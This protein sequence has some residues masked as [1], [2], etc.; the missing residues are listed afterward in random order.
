MKRKIA[1]LGLSLLAAI[2]L[3]SC[4][5]GSS[6]SANCST[7]NVGTA[8]ESVTG[9]TTATVN[10]VVTLSVQFKV[11]NTCGSFQ[12]FFQQT[13]GDMEKTITVNTKYEGCDCDDTVSTKSENFTF[14]PTAPGVYVFKFRKQSIPT[15]EF[16]THTITVP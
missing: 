15:E 7:F 6:S 1:I 16:V 14:T 3:N 8:A 4:D 10:Q 11:Q 9:P 2:V 5:I 12:S 13:T